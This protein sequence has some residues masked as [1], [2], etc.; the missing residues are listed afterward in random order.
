MPHVYH[1]ILNHFF[2]IIDVAQIVNT[3]K[4]SINGAS[5]NLLLYYI[6]ISNHSINQKVHFILIQPAFTNLFEL[7]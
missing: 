7:I 5:V 3:F 2:Y 4:C 1:K 6:Q